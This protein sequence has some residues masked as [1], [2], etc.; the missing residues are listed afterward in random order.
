[1]PKRRNRWAAGL[2]SVAAA[3]ALRLVAA[4]QAS[5]QAPLPVGAQFQINTYTTNT[6]YGGSAAAEANGDFVVVWSSRRS[7]GNDST[8]DSIQGQ[9][10]R[11]SAAAT[12]MPAMSQATRFALVAVLLLGAGY[13]L[14]VRA[15]SRHQIWQRQRPTPAAVTG[16]AGCGS[17]SCVTR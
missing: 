15:P 17:R 7:P 1:M 16:T 14:R 8:S 12:S 3:L 11:V 5:A 2:V 4:S 6:Q 9:R 13:A 10:Y